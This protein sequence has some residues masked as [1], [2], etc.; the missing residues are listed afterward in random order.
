MLRYNLVIYSHGGNR[1]IE[2]SEII[3]H[4][5]ALGLDAGATPDDIRSAFRKLAREFH[6]DVTGQK[7]DF[8]F[9]LITTAYNAVKGLTAEELQA[10]AANNPV[11]DYLRAERQK[12]AKA[13]AEAEARAKTAEKIDVVLDKYERELKEY[14]AGRARAGSPDISAVIL[15]MKSKNPKAIRAILKHSAHLANKTDF[16]RA[17]VELLKRPDIDEACAKIIASFPFEDMTRKLIAMDILNNVG[18]LPSGL[19]LSLAGNDADVIEGM[20]MHIR[21]EDYAALLRRWPAGKVMNAGIMR[22]LLEAN[23]A[24][25]L[26]PLLSLIG[27]NF[28]QSAAQYKKRLGELES[29]PTAAVRAWAKK[30][31]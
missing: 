19:L 29:H 31:V 6:P 2:H 22:N 5:K 4:L 25:I 27:S 18:S 24:R 12:Q 11:Y 17:L 15:R 8:R 28:P 16:R 7:S 20:L 26:V 13:Q 10:I 3:N 9:K 23:D 30:L 21:P 14:Y 1:T